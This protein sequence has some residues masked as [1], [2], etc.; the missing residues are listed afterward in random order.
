MSRAADNLQTSSAE[1]AWLAFVQHRFDNERASIQD[2]DEELSLIRKYEALAKQKRNSHT[3]ACKLPAEIVGEILFFARDIWRPCRTGSAAKEYE[4]GWMSLT[5]VCSFWRSTAVSLPGLWQTI[6]IMDIHPDYS[7]DILARS[8]RG[9]LRLVSFQDERFHEDDLHVV[10]ASRTWLSA[11]VFRRLEALEFIC[12]SLSPIETQ[13]I[14]QEAPGI[15]ALEIHTRLAQVL[16]RNMLNSDNHPSLLRKLNIVGCVL[17]PDTH[18]LAPTLVFLHLNYEAVDIDDTYLTNEL[19]LL[20]I[21]SMSSLET[22]QLSNVS[23]RV[24]HHHNADVSL[25]YVSLPDT[26]KSLTLEENYID[27][28]PLLVGF[29]EHLAVPPT[30]AIEVW[31]YENITEDDLPTLPLC[32]RLLQAMDFCPQSY[33]LPLELYAFGSK[34][35][36][37]PVD[38]ADDTSDFKRMLY[39]DTED[40]AT[41][42][43]LRAFPST[44]IA[45]LD[46]DSAILLRIMQSRA[47]STGTNPWIECFS[48]AQSVENLVVRFLQSAELWTALCQPG[49]GLFPKLDTITVTSSFESPDDLASAPIRTTI[50]PLVLGM[51]EAIELRRAGGTPIRE[52]KMSKNLAGCD[53]W[54][55]LHRLVKVTTL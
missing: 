40:P 46:M 20:A 22:L 2:L 5:H 35:T 24:N 28:L 37:R 12:T 13:A 9:P 10:L 45:S 49:S 41:Y 26:F 50:P 18:L 55:T 7:Y 54:G 11:P 14:V 36:V 53:V 8:A 31:S 1:A 39:L 29:L 33:P 25:P 51:V 38:C 44:R 6:A 48:Q 47:E 30:A 32:H 3:G 43:I 17:P 34:Y 21:S 52:V 16:P 27:Y 23:R 42:E 15:R 4:A 19:L